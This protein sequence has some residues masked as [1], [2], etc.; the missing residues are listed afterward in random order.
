MNYEDVYETA[1]AIGY[2]K[3]RVHPSNSDALFADCEA[4]ESFLNRVPEQWKRVAV[5]RHEQ[6]FVIGDAKSRR[7]GYRW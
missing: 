5:N 6:G 2:H 3:G 7:E 4:Y 1:Y